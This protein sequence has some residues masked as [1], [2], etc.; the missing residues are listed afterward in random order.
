MLTPDAFDL[1]ADGL[2]QRVRQDRK[3]ALP[4]LPLSNVNPTARDIH[5]LHAQRQAFHEPRPPAEQE[6]HRESMGWH[7]RG[8]QP[9]CLHGR[10]HVGRV[11]SA[12]RARNGRRTPRRL[13]EHIIHP[14][15]SRIRA[16]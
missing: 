14:A 12:P 16:A 2:P 4:S 9:R 15:S 1:L 8:Q 5:I 13:A 11:A 6:R 7:D 3:S 10:E